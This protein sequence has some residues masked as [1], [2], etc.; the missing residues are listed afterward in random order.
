MD[1]AIQA[2]QQEMFHP[3]PDDADINEGTGFLDNVQAILE[4]G[5]RRGEV[6]TDIALEKLTR[7]VGVLYVSLIGNMIDMGATNK[8][9]NEVDILLAFIGSAF[10]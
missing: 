7:Y 3:H 1:H 10:R 9:T 4:Y 2:L 5:Q 6:R 8:Y